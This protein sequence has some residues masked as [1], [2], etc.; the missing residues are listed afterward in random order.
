MLPS[1]ISVPENP[2]Q[3]FVYPEGIDRNFAALFQTEDLLVDAYRAS[4]RF[5][6]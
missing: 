2:N 6:F 4:L 5:Q 1:D 3:V